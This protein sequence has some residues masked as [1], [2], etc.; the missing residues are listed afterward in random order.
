MAYL[1]NPLG[2]LLEVTHPN[3]R[4]TAYAYDALGRKLSVDHPD[5]GRTSL[6]YDPAGNLLTR[7]TPNL[8]KLTSGGHVTY[9]YDHER[10]AEVQYPKN[11][12]NRVQYTYGEPGEAHNRAGR[13][14]LVQD[15]SGGAEY[16][17]GKMGEV[18]KT[19]RTLMLNS[20]DV[21]TYVSAARY[22][23]WNR[24]REMDYPDG[25]R[26]AYAYDAAGQL[27][28]V[29]AVRDTAVTRLV[30]AMEYDVYGNVASR[31]YGNGA[32]SRYTY[33]PL[34]QRLSSM[35]ASSAAAGTFLDAKYSY[36]R[37]GNVLG[38]TNAATPSGT[39]GG[40]Y[41]HSYAYDGLSRLTSASG[42]CRDSVSYSLRM[43]YDVM[44]NPLRK[45]LDVS[46]ST[47]ASS[48]DLHY[49]YGGMKPDAV[50]EVSDGAGSGRYTYDENGNPTVIETD[51]TYRQMQWDEENRLLSV[52]DDG[53]VSRYT[54]DHAGRRAIRSHGPVEAVYVDG[55]PQGITYHDEESY[56]LY[57]SPY[58]TVTDGR[59]TKHYYAGAQRIATKL[60]TGSFDN[61]YGVNNF[62]LTAGQKDYAERMVQMETG[63]QAYYKE[64]GVPPG[65]PTQK[66][67]TGEPEILGAA[68]PNVP[69]GNY[70]V[71]DGWPTPPHFN[72][73]G[74]VPG[75][76]VM[77]EEPEDITDPAPGY[78]YVAD[79]TAERDIYFFHTDHLGSTAYLTDRDGKISQFV[80][81]TPYGE[82]LVDE[83]ATTYE[84]PFKFSGKEL[85]D[86]TGLYDHGARSRDPKLTMWYG[87]DP[88]YEKYPDMSPYV[89]CAGNPVN[90]IDPDG[91]RKFCVTNDDGS[92]VETEID[93]GV[94][95]SFDIAAFDL[96][97]LQ[98]AYDNDIS[99]TK[100]D[101]EA[102][103]N[104]LGLGTQGYYLALEVRKW[105]GNTEYAYDK[106]KGDFP[107]NTNKCN[108]FVY[109]RLLDA[110]LIEKYPIGC[111]PQ[112][113]AYADPQTNIKAGKNGQMSVVSD[114]S[115]HLGDVIAGKFGWRDAS[116]HVEIVS[117]LFP[118]GYDP[119]NA[120]N[121]FGTT[122]AHRD[123]IFPS[124]K[125]YDMLNGTANVKFNPVTTRRA[126]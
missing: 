9:V 25:E 110:D 86:I 121:Y 21:R 50:S 89:Y 18:T 74:D 97:M 77:W 71:P 125:G 126:K 120:T 72:A 38:I 100:T 53:Y 79:T 122:G 3:G 75:P 16:F 106:K 58:L 45:T 105:D 63:R 35:T 78:G 95:G 69:L 82:A 40:S 118:N 84:N 88:L 32:V 92:I 119:K 107:K 12:F 6:S 42:T 67:Q 91:M 55:A 109:D 116:G 48:H 17:Y 90:F 101:Y 56:T 108:K 87:V 28:S 70:D 115:V 61:I 8:A 31:T 94:D 81:Y 1:Y 76:P 24:I 30:T 99:E 54:Y 112:A 60:G 64:R 10:L 103:F 27:R 39:L 46:G 111:P 20:S 41:S 7:Q 51:S 22:D 57:V 11:I 65:V 59:F 102:F 80:C 93:D 83:H 26:V 113:G 68:L 14:V 37:I 29:T 43:E 36:D 62:H 85:D 123:S 15:A 5:A 34:R 13:L 49:L 98:Y 104:S 124:S 96:S 117:Y 2:E 4:K 33:D 66:G 114:G 52:D 23:S 19:V 47:V 73:P 44:G